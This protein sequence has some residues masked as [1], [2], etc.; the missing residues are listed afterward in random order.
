MPHPQLVVVGPR[1][2][3]NVAFDDETI[4][5]DRSALPSLPIVVL[6]NK[7]YGRAC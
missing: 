3:A 4:G 1:Y 7:M 5:F 2:T 6:Q